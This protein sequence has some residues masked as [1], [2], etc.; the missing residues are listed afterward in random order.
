M[1]FP[2]SGEPKPIA[3][4]VRQARTAAS[5]PVLLPASHQQRITVRPPP[6]SA[7]DGTLL[8]GPTC[9]NSTGSLLVPR[10]RT[11]PFPL[12][13]PPTFRPASFIGHPLLRAENAAVLQIPSWTSSRSG[14]GATAGHR[15]KVR[16]FEVR[17]G[18][19]SLNWG[20]TWEPGLGA[21]RLHIECT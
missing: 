5:S 9:C 10:R 15:E 8:R 19:H 1:A 20:R 17:S 13:S 4:P 3:S 7:R 18:P 21:G 16:L 11:P 2:Y 14:P 6:P 12:S